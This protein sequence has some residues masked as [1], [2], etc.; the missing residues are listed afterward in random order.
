MGQE[1]KN[2][3]WEYM[4]LARRELKLVTSDAHSQL[5]AENLEKAWKQ[6]YICEGSDW[7]W[8]Y[9]D[10]NEDFDRLYRRHLSNFYTFL[11]KKIPEYLTKPI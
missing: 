4:A 7:F 5:S 11:G 9:G 1:Q 10:N 2:K 6:I 8:W 3:A